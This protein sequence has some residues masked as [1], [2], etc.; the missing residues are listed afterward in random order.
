MILRTTSGLC[1]LLT[2]SIPLGSAER[3]MGL[4]VIE[5]CGPLGDT[6]CAVWEVLCLSWGFVGSVLGSAF[7]RAVFRNASSETDFLAGKTLLTCWP[8]SF[9]TEFEQLIV[10]KVTVSTLL[11]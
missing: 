2:P 11:K 4:G 7:S 10:L 1:H 3:S 9:V 8:A 5:Y 6:W